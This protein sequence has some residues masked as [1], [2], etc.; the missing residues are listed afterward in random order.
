MQLVS[1]AS[2]RVYLGCE[3]AHARDGALAS[4]RVDLGEA[5]RG[6]AGR[7]GAGRGVAGRVGV[8]RAL[9]A[10]SPE[11]WRRGPLRLHLIYT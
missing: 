11:A 7:D 5:W 1:L 4:D 8:E 2:D 9:L 10:R 3:A 6:G